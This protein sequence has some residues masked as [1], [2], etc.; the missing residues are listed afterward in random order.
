MKVTLVKSTNQTIPIGLLYLASEL[1]TNG[2]D[3]AIL[4][5][6]VG[7]Y[8][9]EKFKSKIIEINPQVVG[10][11]CLSFSIQPAF[12]IAKMVK[13]AIPKI[14]VVMGGP[15]PTGLP[16]HTLSSAY[17]DSVVI[18]EGEKTL[19]ELVDTLD[20]G[21]TL[22]GVRGLAYKD[23]GKIIFNQPREYIKDVDS[24][25][26]PAY[27]LIN[28]DSYF[29]LPFDAH[30]I[31]TK[32]QRYMPILTSRG[33]PYGC[34]Y[35]HN[36]FGK[37]F[38]ARSPENVLG[39][40]ELLYN[41]YNIREFHIEDDSFNIDLERAEKILDLIS[42]KDLKISIQ[43]GSGIRADRMNES[44]AKKLKKAGTFM[45]AI[46]VES[47][48]ENT[49]KNVKKSLD[50]SS[51][52][53]AVKLLIDQNILVWTYFM[54]GFMNE[55]RQ[56]IR[57]TIDFAK[58]LKNHFV[59]FSFV[60]PYP[61]TELFER[62]KNRIDLNSYFSG[63]LNFNHPRIQ[64]SEVS[65]EELAD[66]KRKALREFYSPMR[67]LRIAKTIR[68]IREIKFYWQKFKQKFK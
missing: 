35:C 13:E 47:A 10:I 58:K 61:G 55:T 65:I 32:H 64:L 59:S 5:Y 29:A 67:I 25:S 4:D 19:Q 20:A 22:Q 7:R 60:I 27:H 53:T 2:V 45:V 11:N 57:Q 17:V 26:F 49:L 56:E 66:I 50:L 8:N 15:H 46:G 42:N 23:S 14:H 36:I 28:M 51:I 43:F 37:I 68:S 31:I 48:S 40:M 1:E 21:R 34:I 24:I 3:V 39:E 16:E 44:F 62:V 33:C 30:G 9:P 54:I 41:K 63:S 12:E 38:R 18:G 52:P 6:V